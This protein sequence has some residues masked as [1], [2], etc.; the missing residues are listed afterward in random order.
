METLG[1]VVYIGTSGW[2][3]RDWRRSFY[4]EDVPQREWLEFYCR[5]FRTL[6]LN[7]SF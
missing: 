7:N 5:H 6:E 4:P 1:T 2:Q 3:Y